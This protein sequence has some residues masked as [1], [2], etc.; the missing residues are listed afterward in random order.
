MSNGMWSRTL[1]GL[2]H[3]TQSGYPGYHARLPVR[4]SCCA[5]PG[6]VPGPIVLIE[7][8]PSSAAP[9]VAVQVAVRIP[10]SQHGASDRVHVLIVCW[11]YCILVYY[12]LAS[13]V[14]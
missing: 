7:Y 5:R 13:N 10:P 2:D 12:V 8:P 6:H 9:A 14:C 3:R 1:D 4:F 11:G